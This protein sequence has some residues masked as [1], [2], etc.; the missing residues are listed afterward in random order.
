MV[1]NSFATD[2]LQL[3]TSY[4]LQYSLTVISGHHKVSTIFSLK[5]CRRG[6][7]RKEGII[8][9]KEAEG[10]WGTHDG[11]MLRNIL[12]LTPPLRSVRQERHCQITP[13]RG[14]HLDW[15][16][17][18]RLSAAGLR[19]RIGCHVIDCQQHAWGINLLR[20]GTL[21]SLEE[22]GSRNGLIRT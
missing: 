12:R 18:N 1:F 7:R 3:N 17:Y 13:W 8:D 9:V 14:K 19:Y 20:N 11:S 21:Q 5:G 22:D 16:S 6:W 10:Y 2:N 15:M 4:H